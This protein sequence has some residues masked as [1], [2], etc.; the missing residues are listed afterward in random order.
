MKKLSLLVALA[1][2]V[3]IGGVYATWSY[4]GEIATESHMHM[5]VNLATATENTPKGT[6]VNVLNSMDV[7]IDDTDSNYIA[8]AV[9]SGKMGFVFTPGIGASEDVINNGINMQFQVEQKTP[10]KYLGNNI[11]TMKKDAPTALNSTKITDANK[12]TLAA[13]VDLGQYVDSFYVEIDASVMDQH[14]GIAAI[15]LD[16][17]E[18]YKA[19][20]AAL[21]AGGAMGITVSEATG[22]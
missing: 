15:E 11:F 19:M 3:T 21:T 8:E 6:I 16:T 7:K 5:S 14:V 2:L 17:L 18:E 12:T 20:E 9:F 4:A 10:L 22:S 13:G 1:L